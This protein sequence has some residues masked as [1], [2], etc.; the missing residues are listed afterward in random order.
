[1]RVLALDTSLGACSVAALEILDGVEHVRGHVHLDMNRGHAEVLMRLV[2]EVEAAA[3]FGALDVDRLGVT[4][5]P[6]TFTGLRVGLAAAR[7]FALATGKPLVGITSLQAISKGASSRAETL[8]TVLDAKRGDLY[9]GLFRNDKARTPIFEPAVLPINEAVQVIA[10]AQEKASLGLI[11]TGLEVLC[12]H[13]A[14]LPEEAS[15]A[16][17]PDALNIAKLAGRII[18]PE[19]AP[20]DPLYLRGP[21]AKPPSRNPLA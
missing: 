12:K 21:D 8:G 2:D 7:G 5:G 18:D 10:D 17:Q 6:G 13:G 1:M 9:L 11:G 19:S 20:P 15:G 3:G 14:V 16:V 4:T